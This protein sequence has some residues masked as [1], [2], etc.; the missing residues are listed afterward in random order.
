M[1]F[2]V[3]LDSVL[4]I[5]LL[6]FFNDK[7]PVSYY[8]EATTKEDKNDFYHASGPNYISGTPFQSAMV[9]FTIL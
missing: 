1:L 7:V 4:L 9:F 3:P 6:F 2:Y 5:P 8:K